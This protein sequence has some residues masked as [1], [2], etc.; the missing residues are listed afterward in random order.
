MSSIANQRPGVPFPQD[1]NEAIKILQESKITKHEPSEFEQVHLEM[2][3]EELLRDLKTARLRFEWS[4]RDAAIWASETFRDAGSFNTT[5]CQMVHQR[6]VNLEYTVEELQEK[7]ALRD[8]EEIGKVQ[9]KLQDFVGDH[10]IWSY[11]VSG[12]NPE[13]MD[14]PRGVSSKKLERFKHLKLQAEL[15][16]TLYDAVQTIHASL[17]AI[18]KELIQKYS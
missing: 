16:D 13:L 14:E 10:G 18:C 6:I 9:R 4:Q 15:L 17:L 12:R 1:H 5:L 11:P 2:L 8:P 3:L 7:I